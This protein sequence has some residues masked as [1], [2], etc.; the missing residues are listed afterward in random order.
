MSTKV[1]SLTMAARIAMMLAV[2]Q[3]W[4]IVT[5][6]KGDND[7]GAITARVHGTFQDATGGLGVLSGD[8]TIVRFEVRGGTLTAIGEIAGSLADSK[9]DVLGRVKQELLLPVGNVGSSCNQ[10]RMELGAT[11][12]D[13]LQQPIHFDPEVAGFDSRE[14]K[15]TTPKALGVLCV[16]GDV[17]RSNPTPDALAGALNDV[18]TAIASH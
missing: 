7:G 14:G 11:D 6:A 17:I 16:A 15:T 13:V 12:A 18:A 2:G 10:I 5:L 9:G 8:M 4:T 3:P 1:S